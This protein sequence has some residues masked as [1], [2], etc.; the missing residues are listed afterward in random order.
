MK[1]LVGVML[2]PGYVGFWVWLW[3]N[4][5]TAEAWQEAIADAVYRMDQAD[6]VLSG[7]L[8]EPESPE[9]GDSHAA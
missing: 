9:G 2:W 4:Q 7:E 5:D 3:I 1:L 8:D 6:G